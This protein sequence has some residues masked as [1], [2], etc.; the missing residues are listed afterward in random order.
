M[1][2]SAEPIEGDVSALFSARATNVTWLVFYVLFPTCT[3]LETALC[4]YMIA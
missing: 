1:I 4:S 2:C 3:A